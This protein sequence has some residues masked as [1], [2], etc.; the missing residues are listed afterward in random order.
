MRNCPGGKHTIIS[1]LS[2]LTNKINKKS[3]RTLYFEMALGHFTMKILLTAALVTIILGACGGGK[4]KS[5]PSDNYEKG[6]LKVADIEAKAPERFLQVTGSDKRNL[7]GQRVV[8]GTIENKAK[9]I[10]YKDVELRIRFYSKTG[11]LLEEDHET[12]YEEIAP[13]GSQS[14]KSKYFAAKGTDSVALSVVKATPIK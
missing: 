14:F 7:I 1:F 13:G 8:R 5:S 4:D 12:V 9:I 6:K 10:S 3:G 11:I 2:S